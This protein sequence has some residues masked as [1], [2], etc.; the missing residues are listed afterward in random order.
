MRATTRVHDIRFNQWSLL[1]SNAVVAGW[2]CA[3]LVDMCPR[4]GALLK[5]GIGGRGPK[6]RPMSMN[7]LREGLLRL[8]CDFHW[9]NHTSTS[10]FR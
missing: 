6:Q 10:I 7:S 1:I 8:E 4:R 9:R 3:G 2:L 5:N